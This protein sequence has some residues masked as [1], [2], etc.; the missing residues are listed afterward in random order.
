V[1]ESPSVREHLDAT[2]RTWLGLR[3]G[4]PVPELPERLARRLLRVEE[5]EREHRDQWGNWE[6][7]FCEAYREGTLW[8]PEIDRWLAEQRAGGGGAPLWPANRPFAVCLS[9]DV[10]LLS[11]AS[12]PHQALRS[13]R[14]SLT[15]GGSSP[16][17]RVI[18]AA[19][20]AVR[21]ARA[22][23][24]GVARSPTADSLEWCADMELNHG[25]TAT[26]FFTA[27]PG[28]AGH[29]YDCTY[30]FGDR[31]RFRGRSQPI[32][33]VVRA[34]H[35]DGYDIGLH[36][37]YN[38]ALAPGL[39]A[40]ERAALEQA[41]GLTVST[42]RQHFVHWDARATPLL[43]EDAG[44]RADSTLGFN[45]NLGFRTGTSLPHRLFDLSSE[46]RLQLIEVPLVV[47][48]GALFRPDA[49]ELGLDLALETLRSFLDT[50]REVG[51]LATLIF[52][53]NNFEHADY[54]A[55]FE[56]TLEFGLAHGAWFA[57]VKDLDAWWREREQQVGT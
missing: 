5:Y 25:V 9:H 3:S 14:L 42:T 1:I 27:Y 45:R 4:A 48:D 52:H 51:G 37:S 8:E 16:R 20:P 17:G 12:T 57:S 24:N 23:A 50:V 30:D 34:L 6:F 19:R 56:A 53:P 2:V 47:H 41:T 40:R 31:C 22:L 13:M 46:R 15:G 39:L 33:D 10:D 11:P 26:Y 32:R 35:D 55:L 54:R 38:S 43:Q 36:G 49:L 18:R 7:S 29:R 44:L 21:A 28:S